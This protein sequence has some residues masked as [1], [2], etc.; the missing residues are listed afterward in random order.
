MPNAHIHFNGLSMVI[1]L[2]DLLGS[3]CD[4]RSGSLIINISKSIPHVF[5]AS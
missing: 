1:H 4:L 2:D 5:C 3:G